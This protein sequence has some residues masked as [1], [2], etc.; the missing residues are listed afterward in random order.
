M[1]TTPPQ[2]PVLGI[3]EGTLTPEGSLMQ[4][5]SVLECLHNAKVF[6][7]RVEEPNG[8]NEHNRCLALWNVLAALD[9]LGAL[10]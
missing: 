5:G 3:A 8:L 7:Q 6:L 2:P 10:L 4:S 9:K 1:T